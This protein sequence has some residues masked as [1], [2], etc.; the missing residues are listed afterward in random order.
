LSEIDEFARLR[1]LEALAQTARARGVEAGDSGAR[2][3][4][5]SED[6][7]NRRPDGDEQPDDDV[8]RDEL[9]TP[10]GRRRFGGTRLAGLDFGLLSGRRPRLD[11]SGVYETAQRQAVAVAPRTN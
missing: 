6:D 5:A 8:A 3:L 10:E 2:M 1:E 7:G 9:S 4:V 11:G